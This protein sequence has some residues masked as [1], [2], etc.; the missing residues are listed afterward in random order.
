MLTIVDDLV[1]SQRGGTR[2]A[3]ASRKD[4]QKEVEDQQLAPWIQGCLA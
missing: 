2:G 1:C 4:H 3:K